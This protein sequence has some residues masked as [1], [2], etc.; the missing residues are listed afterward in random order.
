M[1]V[2]ILEP[3]L[4]NVLKNSAIQQ[5]MQNKKR[6]KGQGNEEGKPKNHT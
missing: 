3:K 6:K 5:G 2:R 4:E 1:K